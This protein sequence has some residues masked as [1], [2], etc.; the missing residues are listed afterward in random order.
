M[1]SQ[2]GTAPREEWSRGNS[3][4]RP[5]EPR[6]LHP[7]MLLSQTEWILSGHHKRIKLFLG[8][9]A[10]TF[11]KLRRNRAFK[12]VLEILKGLFFP[13]VIKVLFTNF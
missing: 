6:V 8:S 9:A 3:S 10:G 11:V 4:A 2:A 1:L 7:K 12:K 5:A 13:A